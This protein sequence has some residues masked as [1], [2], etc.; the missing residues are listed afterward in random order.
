[1]IVSESPEEIKAETQENQAE[2]PLGDDDG[3]GGCY[4]Y[5]D[6]VLDH[7]DAL[8]P[9]RDGWR[10]LCPSHDDHTPSLSIDVGEGGRVLVKCWAGCD[11]E[12]IVAAA[13]LE[14]KDLFCPEREEQHPPT[15]SGSGPRSSKAV[16]NCDFLWCQVYDF[17]LRMQDYL[18]SHHL[19]PMIKR[20]FD[21]GDLKRVRYR[22]ITPSSHPL[23]INELTR[24]HGS[25][26]CDVPGFYRGPHDEPY[27]V[28]WAEGMLIPV[29]D[30]KGW[31]VA[32]KLRRHGNAVPKYLW[33]SSAKEGGNSPGSPCHVPLWGK[34]GEG[35]L[36]IPSPVEAVRIVEGEL[37]ADL[38][39][40]KTGI[41]TIGV[42]GVANWRVALPVLDF[43]RK[44]EGVDQL[45][46]AVAFD[47]QD[48][49]GGN[50]GVLKALWQCVEALDERGYDVGVEHWDPA[51]KGPDDTW[52]AGAA[53]HATWGIAAV[54][55]LLAEYVVREE[56][57]KA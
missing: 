13:G 21:C 26:F 34:P 48:V 16:R 56:V 28:A 5:F 42:T 14:M 54:E 1:M 11:Q 52:V 18:P 44:R 40:I 35:S 19:E 15:S 29:R 36:M 7:F 23:I 50:R 2:E 17:L 55:G 32:L 24:R 51:H 9:S 4:P 39:T 45:P 37:A 27:I 33:L 10:A 25:T 57:G 30:V 6:R 20:G 47:W 3:E 12:A 31:P 46:V 38:L 53:L 43:L 41:L 22:N 8:T 49:V